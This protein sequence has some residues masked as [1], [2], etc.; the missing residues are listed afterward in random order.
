MSAREGLEFETTVVSD[1][2]PLH[3]LVSA[4]LAAGRCIRC[5]RDATRGGVR[6]VAIED[7]I[8]GCRAILA[9][10]GDEW[11]ESSLYM[12][13]TLE[14]ARSKELSGRAAGAKE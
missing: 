6:S 13:G 11:A 10:E 9:G 4:M 3:E 1:C 5:M 14:D 7:T 2:A 12:V 8:K